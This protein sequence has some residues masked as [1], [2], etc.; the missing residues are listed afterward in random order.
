MNKNIP[1][2]VIMKS[3]TEK[4]DG[5]VNGV[6]ENNRRHQIHGKKSLILHCRMKII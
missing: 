3:K 4:Y 1:V 2:S 5:T 6:D